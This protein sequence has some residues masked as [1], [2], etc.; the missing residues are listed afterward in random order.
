MR[1]L[2]K[3]NII[4]LYPL[5]FIHNFCFFIQYF[6]LQWKKWYFHCGIRMPLWSLEAN[7]D[8]FLKCLLVIIFPFCLPTLWWNIRHSR[9]LSPIPLQPVLCL[10]H[11]PLLLT[12]PNS[13]RSSTCFGNVRRGWNCHCFCPNWPE[14]ADGNSDYMLLGQNDKEELGDT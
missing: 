12:L 4:F 7:F 8:S 6:S 1:N 13:Q 5:F 11:F 3:Q 2:K 9:I 10:D 14:S